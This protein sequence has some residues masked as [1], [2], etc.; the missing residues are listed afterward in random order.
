MS[1]DRILRHRGADRLFHWVM[2]A[3]VL[4]LLAT[5]LAPQLGLRFDW[6]PLHW[7]A[8]LLLVAALLYHLVRVAAR[9]TLATMR[10]A[11]T[12]VAQL[13][14]LFGGPAV[15]PG[16]YSLAQKAMHHGV[17]LLSLAAAATGVVMMVKVDTPFW[18]RNP[19]WLEAGTWG[20]VYVVHGLAALCFVSVV[21]LHLYFALRPEKRCYLEAMRGGSMSRADWRAHHDPALWPG[22]APPGQGPGTPR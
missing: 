1:D 5:G 7:S 22:E 14:A 19:Y 8:G 2:A 16:K 9:R 13:R 21:M 17:A 10:P 4:A 15:L 18:P 11:P 12:D 6:V 3:S 20:V